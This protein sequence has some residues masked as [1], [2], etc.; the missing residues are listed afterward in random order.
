MGNKYLDDIGIRTKKGRVA[1]G[2]IAKDRKRFRKQRE[3]YGFD[4]RECWSLDFSAA[5]WLYSHLKRYRKDASGTVD[6]EYYSFGIPVLHRTDRESYRETGKG[7]Y[8]AVTESHTQ[9]ECIDICIAYLKAFL[10]R[11]A[12]LDAGAEESIGAEQRGTEMGQ[13]AFRIFAEILPAMWW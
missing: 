7:W 10:L 5:A 6:L 4:S 1:G 8:E 13:C 12:D 3:K 11:D 2:G 9:L